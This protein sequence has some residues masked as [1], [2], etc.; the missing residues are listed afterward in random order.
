MPTIPGESVLGISLSLLTLLCPGTSSSPCLALAPY[1]GRISPCMGSAMLTRA[2]SLAIMTTGCVLS[3][4]AT[5]SSAPGAWLTAQLWKGRVSMWTGEEVSWG[6]VCWGSEFLS[7]GTVSAPSYS[8]SRKT[9]YL[10][11]KSNFTK[12]TSLKQSSVTK[13]KHPKTI[14]YSYSV[15]NSR[16]KT[17]K[18]RNYIASRKSV[19]KLNIQSL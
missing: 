17:R 3:Y 1:P 7:F 19:T 16:N 12:S 14:R 5:T 10:P 11:P 6:Q 15:N 13:V 8:T 18:V 2:H 4:F 9:V